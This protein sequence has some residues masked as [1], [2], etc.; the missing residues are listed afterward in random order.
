M[1]TQFQGTRGISAPT[2]PRR[3]NLG[4]T[5]VRGHWRSERGS[6]RGE[7]IAR[8]FVMKVASQQGVVTASLSLP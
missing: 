3:Q 5:T 1:N 4:P 8:D 6:T 2:G 7:Q